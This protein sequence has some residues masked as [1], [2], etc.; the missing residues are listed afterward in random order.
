METTLSRVRAGSHESPRQ[1]LN[2][3]HSVA[4]GVGGPGPIE[5]RIWTRYWGYH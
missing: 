4:G 3:A 2:G 5:V 1:R